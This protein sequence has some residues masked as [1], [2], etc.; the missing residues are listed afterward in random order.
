MAEDLKG[1]FDQAFRA[2]DFVIER[3]E[4]PDIPDPLHFI[5]N[6]GTIGV[7]VDA[8][9]RQLQVAPFQSARKQLVE[10]FARA[11]DDNERRSLVRQ[12]RELARSATEILRGGKGNTTV[13]EEVDKQYR[14]VGDTAKR[15]AGA[16]YEGAKS[17]VEKVPW[18][19]G[20]TIAAT[21]LGLG[22]VAVIRRPSAAPPPARGPETFG[23]G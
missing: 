19:V 10:R 5:T 17:A 9:G 8:Y 22:L 6:L 1:Q 11:K 14:E 23:Y 13:S 15:A 2:L 3:A 4:R 18:I 7:L 16:L 12:A 20:G 21:L